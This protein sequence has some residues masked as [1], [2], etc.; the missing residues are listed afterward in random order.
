[1]SNTPAGSRDNRVDVLRGLAL[2]TIFI[3]H[4]PGNVFETLTPR[5]FGF[6]D[7]AEVFVL[8]AGFA[9]YHAYGRKF[10]R[11][12]RQ[13]AMLKS[14]QRAR[15]LYI[16]HIAMTLGAVVLLSAASVLF[17]RTGYLADTL[18]GFHVNISI[19]S[20]DPW[21]SLIGILTGGHQLGYFNILPMYMMLLLGLPLIMQLARN[22]VGVLI[23]ASLALWFLAGFFAIDMPNFPKPGGWYF[24]PFAWQLLFVIGYVLARMQRH[25]RVV[26]FSGPLFVASLLFLEFACLVVIFK[27]WDL[28]PAFPLPDRL[29][30]YDKGYVALPRL[31][32]V[33]ALAYFVMMSPLGAWLGRVSRSNPLAVMGRNSLPVFCWGSLLCI[34]CFIARTELHGGVLADTMLIGGGLTL[35]SAI[36]YI[37]E[38]RRPAVAA[39]APQAAPALVRS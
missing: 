7:A 6:S 26:P 34:V 16:W 32:H 23:G 39:P 3:N 4:V 25:G 38:R 10:D 22:G 21:R 12:E 35:L 9:A 15:T 29:W 24:N 11:G 14:W 18:A 30:N 27:Q 1:M 5:N 36:G 28:F 8:L 19:L 20:T 2:A 13:L 33:L 37:T 31:L 17:A